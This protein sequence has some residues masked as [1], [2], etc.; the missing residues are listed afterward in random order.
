MADTGARAGEGTGRAAGGEQRA[1]SQRPTGGPSASS[2]SSASPRSS[3]ATGRPLWTTAKSRGGLQRTSPQP[4]ASAA[5]TDTAQTERLSWAAPTTGTRGRLGRAASGVSAGSFSP[6]LLPSLVSQ[7]W[8]LRSRRGPRQSQQQPQQHQ[9]AEPAAMPSTLQRQEQVLL[10]TAFPLGGPYVSGVGAL[11]LVR[12][13]SQTMMQQQ[14]EAS[15]GLVGSSLQAS[16]ARQDAASASLAKTSTTLAAPAPAC[17]AART[18]LAA[19]IPDPV[20]AAAA[21]LAAAPGPA[22]SATAAAETLEGICTRADE[23]S[24]DAATIG[25]MRGN[26]ISNNTSEDCNEATK[27]DNISLRKSYSAGTS[28]QPPKMRG[29]PGALSSPRRRGGHPFVGIFTVPLLPRP[30]AAA[31]A[32]AGRRGSDAASK[33]AAP[34]PDAVTLAAPEAAAACEPACEMLDTSSNSYS[35]SSLKR[36]S[37]TFSMDCYSPELCSMPPSPGTRSPML[38]RRPGR[39]SGTGGT[40][41]G[42]TIPRSSLMLQGTVPTQQQQQSL[43]PQQQPGQEVQQRQMHGQRGTPQRQQEQEPQPERRQQ[44]HRQRPRELVRRLTLGILTRQRGGGRRKSRSVWLSHS[45][46]SSDSGSRRQPQH[47][48]QPPHQEE[49]DWDRCCLPQPADE[50]QVTPMDRSRTSSSNNTEL[51][52]GLRRGG[53]RRPPSRLQRMASSI[54]CLGETPQ[55]RA[56]AKREDSPA[57]ASAQHR[58]WRTQKEMVAGRAQRLY[59]V[60][61][62]VQ[63]LTVR[64]TRLLLILFILGFCL[65]VHIVCF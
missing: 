52:E 63:L 45:T 32:S 22:T 24:R 51:G 39:P 21:A 57:L 9:D 18:G 27:N 13:P 5:G 28:Q 10:P 62:R 37:S 41:E 64:Q 60:G 42:P 56:G 53:L 38:R 59:G 31:A 65:W 23:V 47:Q 61:T 17:G 30:S 36:S 11:G 3:D 20:P 48:Q 6:G 50:L 34:E 8:L 55:R 4:A 2:S 40:G 26:T 19:A 33:S 7:L 15:S 16:E 58:V 1:R 44:H 54:A 35:R 14:M 29:S 12:R 46:S 49:L 25:S 43:Q